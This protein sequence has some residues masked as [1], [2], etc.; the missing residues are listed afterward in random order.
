[1]DIAAN[2]KV[3]CKDGFYGH[4]T[5]IILNPIT[6]EITHLVVQEDVI[7]YPERLVPIDLVVSS[8]PTQTVLRLSKSELRKLPNFTKTEFLQSDLPSHM[9]TSHLMWPYIVSHAE[10]KTV[11]TRSI[12]PDELAVHRGAMVE[13]VDGPVGHLDK[14]VVN[15]ANGHVTDL[16][17]REGHLWGQKEMTVPITEIDHI[18]EDTVYLKLSKSDV[19]TRLKQVGGGHGTAVGNSVTRT[20]H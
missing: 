19:E 4:V 11:E 7:T 17:I 14:F 13:A 20:G 9:L 8:S 15:Q 5:Y 3:Y 12:P 18:Q 2:T 10:M 1:M 6:N 16:V